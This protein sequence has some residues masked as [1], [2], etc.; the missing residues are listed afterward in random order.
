MRLVLPSQQNTYSNIERSSFI[1][2]C[3]MPCENGVST[4]HG[5]SGNSLFTALATVKASLSA[6]P[7]IHITRSMLVVESTSEASTMV[8]T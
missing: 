2:L 1:I 7:G 6:F 4:T 3:V 5:I 8:L